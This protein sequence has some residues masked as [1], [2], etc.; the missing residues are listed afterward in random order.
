M[1]L[2]HGVH[3]GVPLVELGVLIGVP[4]DLKLTSLGFRLTWLLVSFN[5]PS[6]LESGVPIGVLSDL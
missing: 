2:S 4:S 3:I 6:N 1:G 5:V